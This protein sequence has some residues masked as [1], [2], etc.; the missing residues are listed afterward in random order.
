M[1]ASRRR[2]TG[3]KSEK[4]IHHFP[5]PGS[6]KC[7]IYFFTIPRSRLVLLEFDRK[8]LLKL[9][10]DL[11]QIH[12]QM[13]PTASRLILKDVNPVLRNLQATVPS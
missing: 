7:Q 12:R 10:V 2:D 13:R 9:L 8:L 1:Q 4:S 11:V 6:S 5:H 3:K